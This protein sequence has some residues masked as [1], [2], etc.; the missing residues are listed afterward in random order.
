MSLSIEVVKNNR[1]VDL[2]IFNK[3]VKFFI[4]LYKKLPSISTR[5]HLYY[6]SIFKTVS[7]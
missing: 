1:Y 4:I 7:V 3:I 2:Y 5:Q 6:N